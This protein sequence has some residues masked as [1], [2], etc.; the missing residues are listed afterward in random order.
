MEPTFRLD[1]NSKKKSLRNKKNQ[2]QNMTLSRMIVLMF[3]QSVLIHYDEFNEK[4]M[5][6]RNKNKGEQSAHTNNQIRLHCGKSNER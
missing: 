1:N 6:Y 5:R 4:S 3:K 2:R